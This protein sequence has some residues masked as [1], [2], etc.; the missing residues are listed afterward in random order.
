MIF[1]IVGPTGVGKSSL[2][3]EYSLKHDALIVNGDVFQCYKEMN[4]GT[5]KPPLEERKKVPHYLFDIATVTKEYTIYDYQKDLRKTLDELIPLNKDIIIVG[6]SGLYLKSSLYDFNLNEVKNKVDMSLYE[7]MD[8]ETLY[9]KLQDIDL[10]ASKNIHPNNRKRVIR[11]IE[12]YL[13]SGEKK[14]DIINKQEH[15]LL[16]DVCFIGLSKQREELYS[17]IN[18]RVDK[19]VEDGLVE[20]VRSLMEQYP[21]SL[22]A[23]QAI[24]YKE[25]MEGLK[26]TPLSDII[27]L[28]KQ[29]TRNY[30]KRQYTYFNHQ[31]PVNWF[32]S[33]S[34]A[35]KFMEEYHAI[36]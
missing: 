11:A 1:V 36:K 7:K 35:L 4:I 18:Q 19:M 34:D 12:I 13:E 28:I 23:F 2:A 6:G 24:G 15:K 14:S 16:Y 8:N 5:A 31:L 33:K 25:L 30:A 10:E 21:T 27:N 29:R 3:L 9:K 20:E 26:T 17:L 22:R 32:S